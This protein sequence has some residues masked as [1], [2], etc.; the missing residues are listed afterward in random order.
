MG[1]GIDVVPMHRDVVGHV[2]PALLAL[3]GA[4]AFVLLIA[5][6][7]VANLLLARATLRRR[8]MAVR[9]ALGA[10]RWR[11]ARQVLTE[12]LLLALLGGLAGLLLARLGIELLLAFRPPD[13]PR[14]GEIGID[15]RVLA[16]TLGAALV[17]AAV[18]GLAPVLDARPG[19]AG[20]ALGER[21]GGSGRLRLRGALVVAEVALSLLLLVGAGLMLRTLLEISR[22]RPGFEP[23]GVMTF[24]LSLPFQRYPQPTDRTGFFRQLDDRL[25]GLPGVE[26]V[27][28]VFP[29]PLGGRFWTGPY[30][31]PE[32][33]PEEWTRNEASFRVVT[34]GYFEA[35][36]VRRLAGRTFEPGDVDSQRE[37][38]VVDAALA[39]KLWGE[40]SPL[41]ER[42]GIDL[43]GDRHEL[44]VVGVVEPVLHNEVTAADRE[45][46]YFPQ[47]LV[48]WVPMTTA[49]RT[50]AAPASLTG[51]IRA[52]VAAMDPELAVYGVAPMERYVH[53]ATASTRFTLGLITAFA[54][55]ALVLAAVG[56][57]GVIAYAVRQRTRE[58]GIRMA[59]GARR[60]SILRL[61]VGR[62]LVLIGL[63]IAIGVAAAA[64]LTRTVAGL[65]YNVA[66]TDPVTF[67]SVAALLV[68]VAVAASWLPAR[69]AAEI[70]PTQSLR[71]E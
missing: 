64:A 57:F 9:V 7:N 66:P 27:G 28:G 40:R 46:V 32:Q 17:A 56:L 25:A 63:G 65:L 71:A 15:L 45:T 20:G 6:A 61:V 2:R 60:S 30:G 55:V 19:R 37:V 70:D 21:A 10:G 47:H 35:M 23:R 12:G 51:P 58:I 29:L 1:I 4:V 69:R 24:Q 50:A 31:L 53:Q 54:A 33:P 41:G 11:L 36:G 34:A 67:A 59:L 38:A 22:V 39:G 16:V 68:A 26:A 8:E 13:L 52:Q 14:V 62:G 5:C 3:A 43:F 42:I 48:P 18:F 44:E 49:V